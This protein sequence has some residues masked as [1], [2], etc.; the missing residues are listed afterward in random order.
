MKQETGEN[1]DAYQAK[2]DI[3]ITHQGMDYQN[4]KQLC[5]DLMHYNFPKLHEEAMR[6]VNEN[7]MALASELKAVI[8]KK[9]VT[10]PEKLAQP[11][12]QAAL[13]EAV[14]GAAKK[15]KKADLN[16]LASLVA[17]RIDSGNSDLLDITIEEAIRLTPKLTREHINFLSINHFVSSVSLQMQNVSFGYLEHCAAPVL[18]AFGLNCVLSEPNIQY[19]AGVG[20][21]NFN[22]MVG[23]DAY[24]IQFQVYPSL[25]ENR[26]EFKERVKGQAPSLNKLLELYEKE[27]FSSVSLNTFGQVIA[28]TNLGRI[29]G[30]MDLKKWIN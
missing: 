19:L 4:V 7:V 15:G 29:F 5:L 20:V 24:D 10:A 6:Q 26:Q 14:Q 27:K 18:A 22:P 21:L 23:H 2:R 25:A 28:L 11:D 3:N 1:S 16:L 8:A 17:S 30:D 13:N 12:V 9:A